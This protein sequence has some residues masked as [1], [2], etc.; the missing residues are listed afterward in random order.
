MLD[1]LLEKTFLGFDEK[2]EIEFLNEIRIAS[3][4]LTELETMAF[5]LSKEN[6]WEQAEEILYSEEFL[7]DKADYLNSLEKLLDLI[8]NEILQHQ[9]DAGELQKLNIYLDILLIIIVIALGVMVTLMLYRW[10]A[11]EQRSYREMSIVNTELEEFTYRIS[12]DLRS[13]IVSSIKLLS[14]TK[15]SIDKQKLEKAVKST[16]LAQASLEKLNFLIQDILSITEARNK[17][18]LDSEVNFAALLSESV[19]KLS[20]LDGFEEIE[21]QKKP[22]FCR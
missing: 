21:I 16:S 13:P 17:S 8:N 4:K 9:K 14:I 1:T 19:A 10:S 12:H 20:N 18:E 11:A 15:D 5:A 3:H 6:K 22:E 2:Q 7:T